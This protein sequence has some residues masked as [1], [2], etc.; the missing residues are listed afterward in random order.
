[1]RNPRRATTSFKI[2]AAMPASVAARLQR[3]PWYERHPDLGPRLV[4]FPPELASIVAPPPVPAA[5]APAATAPAAG[6]LA[7]SAA[8][9]AGKSSARDAARD[10]ARDEPK[11]VASPPVPRRFGWFRTAWRFVAGLCRGLW[12]RWRQHGDH[13]PADRA[14]F[15][16]DPVHPGRHCHGPT[17]RC[18]R[19]HRQRR[20]QE[21]RHCKWPVYHGRQARRRG[22]L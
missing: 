7:A 16:C 15:A 18:H 2:G 1:M 9:L 19:H 3:P 22:K 14:D 6:A 4:P 20:R 21:N 11:P 12:R 13:A 8:E 17:G 10:V 5:T